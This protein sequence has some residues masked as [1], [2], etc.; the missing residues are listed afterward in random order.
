MTG[1]ASELPSE[2]KR[3]YDDRVFSPFFTDFLGFGEFLNFGY[4]ERGMVTPREAGT[5][6][7]TKLLDFIP[8]KNGAILDVAC[9]KG[10]STAI[11]QRSYAPE[12][13]TGI[14]IS[15]RQL[16]RCKE[17][18][19]GSTF[20]KMDAAALEFGDE[21][22]DAILCVEAAFHFNTRRRFFEKAHRVLKPGGRLVLS[23]VL[24]TREAERDRER[25]L[26]ENFVADPAEYESILRSAGFDAVEVVDATRPCWHGYY[27]HWVE[28]FHKAYLEGEITLEQLKENL[29]GNYQRAPILTFYLLAWAE[30]K[31]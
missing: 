8:E 10:A 3:F 29:Q 21:T 5:N 27:W 16:E 23:D 31:G 28:F 2:I 18:A 30:K 26:E 19:P 17:N 25:H 9:G 6:L 13:I 22:F 14:N 15:D 11:L 4:W 20:L 24:M 12:N 7:V 1:S